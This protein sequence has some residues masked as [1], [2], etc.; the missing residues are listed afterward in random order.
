MFRH[1]SSGVSSTLHHSRAVLS[2]SFGSICFGSLILGLI[3]TMKFIS[4]AF[5]RVSS[6][7]NSSPARFI[8]W[9]LNCFIFSIEEWTPY[10]LIVVGISG[11]DLCSSAKECT[12]LFRRNL[13]LGF[14]S[15]ILSKVMI[16]CGNLAVASIV[17]FIVGSL[18]T[19]FE[20]PYGYML[21]YVA[22]LISFYMLRFIGNIIL[23]TMDA[24]FICYL[25]D[26]D[27]NS[28]KCSSAHRLFAV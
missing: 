21:I 22:T 9:T 26:L 7:S 24:T 6:S 19:H 25:L 4:N 18:Q 20:H 17:G 23:N 5:K 1:L 16:M 14:V 28:C 13:V 27:S 10:T 3:S 15:S 11:N 12:H 8:S 2:T